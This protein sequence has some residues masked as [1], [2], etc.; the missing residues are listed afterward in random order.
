MDALIENSA[1]ILAEAMEAYRPTHIVS[2]V[3][4]G[5]DSAASDQI[6]RELGVKIDYVM[7]GNTR[8][9][10]PR[11]KLRRGVSTASAGVSRSRRRS[12]HGKACSPSFS[13]CART[14]RGLQND[15]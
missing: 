4:G 1:R 15:A 14:A 8:C 5:K 6:A 11:W 10:I 9:G 2:M 7:H 13:R 12:T 3:S